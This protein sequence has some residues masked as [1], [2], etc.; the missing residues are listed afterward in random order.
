M[1]KIL[2]IASGGVVTHQE[3]RAW[4]MLVVS[5]VA[6]GVY[7]GIILSRADGQ[8]L[9]QVPYAATLLWTIGASILASIVL[10]IALGVVNP[11]ASRLKDDR[12]RQIG[13]LGDYTGQ[14]FVIIGA[15]AAM[16][17]AMAGWDRFW[18]ANVIYLCFFLSAV[19]GAATKIIAY[20]KSFP[21]W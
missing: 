18:I 6:Y 21:Q 11:R 7:A 3:K 12:D 14:S 9:P 19:L 13:R 1:S 2:D 15:V 8:P 4:I 17:M 20:R 10:E 16:L 5:T